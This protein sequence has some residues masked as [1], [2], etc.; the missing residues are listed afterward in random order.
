VV[1]DGCG[2]S[3]EKLTEIRRQLEYE[4]GMTGS[5]GLKNL[6]GRLHI[7]YNGMAKMEIDSTPGKGTVVILYIPLNN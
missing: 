3:P 1:D 4:N 7:L 2:M 6:A 5:I